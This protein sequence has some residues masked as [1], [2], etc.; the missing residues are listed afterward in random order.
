MKLESI[1]SHPILDIPE[2]NLVG[3]SFDGEKIKGF[4]NMMLSSALFMNGI[5]VFGHHHKDNSPQGIYCAN[6]QCS[7]CTVLVNGNPVK[8]CMTPLKDGMVVSSCEGHPELPAI[9]TSVPMKDPSIIETEVLVIGAGPSGLSASRLLGENGV[10]VLL[11]DDKDR[12]GGKLVLQTHKFFG[13]QQDVYAG[14]RGTTIGEILGEEVRKLKNVDTWLNSNA[15]AV[16]RDGIVGILKNNKEYVLVKPQRLLIATGAREKML[17]FPGGTL[18]GVY[19]AGAFQTLVNRDLVRCSDKIF[20]V[21]GGNVGLIAGYHAIQAGIE[22]V[23]LIEALPRCGGYHVHESKL[24]RLG[25]PIYT[26]HTIVSANGEGKAESITIGQLDEKWKVI[27]GTEK[28]F[29]CDTILIAVGLSPVD[30]FYAKAKAYNIPAWIAGDAQEIAEASAAIFTG[31]VEAI[32]I[33][34]D[35]NIEVKQNLEELEEKAAIMKAHPPAPRILDLPKMENKIIPAF[36]CAQE[37]PCNPCSTV[38]PQ[39]LIHIDGKIT[40]I[41]Y[42]QGEKDCIGCGRCIAVCPGLAITLIDYRKEEMVPKVTFPYEIASEKL[43]K[44]QKVMVM[45]DAGELGEFEVIR[46]RNLKEYPRT[47]LITLVLPKEIAQ[48]AIGIRPLLHPIFEPLEIYH[49]VPVSDEAIVCRCER[50]TAAEIRKWIR[51]GIT[52]MNQL[53]AIT[54]AGMGSCGGKTCTILIERL[55]REEGIPMDQITPGVQRPLFVEVPLGM[56]AG[57]TDEEGK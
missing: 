31:R 37:I 5:K 15:L 14:Q 57:M 30:E 50:V 20:I 6:G 51:K 45:D 46:A 36:H 7:Q 40:N 17:I 32:K 39:E 24:R 12:T 23:G 3:F 25:V 38:C 9:D 47:Q 28:T 43:E 55:M 49:K 34:H 42:F 26:R 4:E 53:K 1:E 22:V 35:M 16:F 54:R 18:P 44:G 48:R 11:V 10:K 27:P 41:P 21:G 2:R 13:S 33:L 52:D 56:F 29:A 19:G 8:S